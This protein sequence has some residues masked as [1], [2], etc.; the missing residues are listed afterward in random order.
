MLKDVFCDVNLPNDGGMVRV[1]L[2][3][4][5]TDEDKLLC[6]MCAFAT[7]GKD[8]DVLPTDDWLRNRMLK[9]RHSP[10]RELKFVF[11]FTNLPAYISTHFAR[12][13]HSRPYI[14]SQRN[15]RQRNYDRRKA[16]QDAP[17]IMIWSMDAEELMIVMNKR[18]CA[19][20]AEETRT[21]VKA[22]RPLVLSHAPYMSGMMVPMCE[23]HNGICYESKGCGKAVKA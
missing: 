16:P 18:L 12:H 9:P 4:V 11:R 1:E 23:Y 14:Q 5:P 15:D 19:M 20:A 8:T 3:R 6:K 17:V 21:I 2:I 13:I 10:I 22:M 7:E